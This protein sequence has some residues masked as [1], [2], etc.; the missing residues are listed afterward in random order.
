MIRSLKIQ[1]FAPFRHRLSFDSYTS[2]K[3]LILAV[4][5]VLG[6]QLVW[7]IVTPVGPFGDWHPAAPRTLSVEAQ[8]ALL[9]TVDPFF[10]SGAA[11]AAA[12]V[13]APADLQL[14]GTRLGSDGIAGSA[15]IGQADGEQRSFAVGE[16]VAPGVKLAAVYFDRVELDRGGVRQSLVMQGASEGAA[17]SPAGR[18]AVSIADAF[19]FSPRTSGG[20]VTGVIVRPGRDLVPFNASGLRQGDV[21]VA[22]NGARITSLIDI[23]QLQASLA[24]GARLILTVERGAQTLPIPLNL[25]ANQ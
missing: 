11:G 15:I 8:S 22:V 1:A 13:A 16:E 20:S 2:L 18:P 14:F 9:S 5:A 17:A 12:S 6:T 7:A 25:P 19:S 21:I 24:P 23:Q 3:A 10:R 4:L